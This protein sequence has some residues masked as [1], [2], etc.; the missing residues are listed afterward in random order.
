MKKP[1]IDLLVAILLISGTVLHAQS[2]R[3]HATANRAESSQQQ[4]AQTI[5]RLEDEL[6]VAIM[7]SDTGWFEE[8]LASNYLDIDTQ[9]KISNRSQIIDFY[10]TSPPEYDSWN[11]SDATAFTYNGNTV[12]LTG[13]LELQSTVAGKQVNSAYRFL[14]VWIK[15]GVDWQLA[16]QQETRIPK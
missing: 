15:E 14:H 12:I 9:G 4:T 1:R 6:R 2:P 11:L 3:K 7:K 5:Q 8:H 16:A 10:R 13:K